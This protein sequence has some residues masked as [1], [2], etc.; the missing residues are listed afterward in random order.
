MV[1]ALARLLARAFILTPHARTQRELAVEP[2]S[3]VR[4]HQISPRPTAR[5]ARRVHI[6]QKVVQHIR[7]LDTRTVYTSTLDRSTDS[8][9][10]CFEYIEHLTPHCSVDPFLHLSRLLPRATLRYRCW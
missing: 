8:T 1:Q 7:A 9:E 2:R 10:G 4:S 6:P 5:I 3:F